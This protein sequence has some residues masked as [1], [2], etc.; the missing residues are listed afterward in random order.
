MHRIF[1][2]CTARTD[3]PSTPSNEARLVCGRPSGKSFTLAIIAVFL[4]CF[5]DWLPYL[6]VCERATVMVIAADRQ[7]A[8]TIIRYV[9]GLLQ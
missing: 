7:Q 3:R 1:I 6:G 9:K 8:R 2:E 4:S 5:R